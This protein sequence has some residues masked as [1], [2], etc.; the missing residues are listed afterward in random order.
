MSTPLFFKPAASTYEVRI[1]ENRPVKQ[2][3]KFS[4]GVRRAKNWSVKG[5]MALVVMVFVLLGSMSFAPAA[6]AD[7][8]TDFMKDTFCSQGFWF[9]EPKQQLTWMQP[10]TTGTANRDQMKLTVY[11]K[12]GIAPNLTVWTGPEKASGLKGTGTF[13]GKKVVE[14]GGFPDDTSINSWAQNVPNNKNNDKVAGSHEGFFSTKG[15]GDPMATGVSTFG[16]TFLSATAIL[17]N[18]VNFTFQFALEGSSSL[19][20]QMKP[21]ILIMAESLKDALYLEFITPVISIGALY[22]AYMGMVKRKTTE[23]VSG[24]IWMVGAAITGWFMIANPLILPSVGNAVVQATTGSVVSAF[25]NVVNSASKTGNLCTVDN[26]PIPGVLDIYQGQRR[27]VR[28][29]QCNVYVTALLD[30]WARAQFGETLTA[31]DKNKVGSGSREGGI[32]GI[33]TDVVPGG[34]DNYSVMLGNVAADKP[35]MALLQME[36]TIHYNKGQYWDDDIQKRL[37]VSIAA[38]QLFVDGNY[39]KDWRGEN[40]ENRG[41]TS[42]LALVGAFCLA[43]PIFVFGLTLLGATLTGLLLILI[44][45]IMLLIGVHPGVGRR[46]SLAWLEAWVAS[47]VLRVVSATLMSMTVALI[48]L[49]LNMGLDPISTLLLMVATSVALIKMRK[50]IMSRVKNINLG[51]D[52]SVRQAMGNFG[53]EAMKPFKNTAKMA[54]AVALGAATGGV[55]AAVAG[56]LGAIGSNSGGAGGRKTKHASIAEDSADAEAGAAAGAGERPNRDSMSHSGTDMNESRTASATA[57][58]SGAGARPHGGSVAA[59][60]ALPA[61]KATHAR[62]KPT[63]SVPKHTNSTIDR[64]TQEPNTVPA[65]YTAPVGSRPKNGASLPDL[66]E[67]WKAYLDPSLIR[68]PK[69]QEVNIHTKER[70]TSVLKGMYEGGKAALRTDSLGAAVSAGKRASQMHAADVK[71]YNVSRQRA[72]DAELR[73]AEAKLEKDKKAVNAEA[74]QRIRKAKQDYKNAQAVAKAKESGA[75]GRSK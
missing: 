72:I 53:S 21:T 10:N 66:D 22:L 41:V 61:G 24:L 11:E 37:Y 42:T 9:A 45:P 2:R 20:E 1:V 15:C 48:G 38:N 25:A 47:N 35:S 5:L 59:G 31:E 6:K 68:A 32:R 64:K 46:I 39:N 55:S 75:G 13:G 54:G 8:L 26:T 17:V 51:G 63:V 36:A 52:T 60:G 57:A 49:F 34:F 73:K 23:F 71:R 40:Y 74:V 29:F 33:G 12:F 30:P 43:V 69:R 19:Y 3:S 7:P 14:W 4:R 62:S 70:K 50:D 27:T 44:A 56:G 67:G 58:Y 28:E 18:L 65:T 16:N